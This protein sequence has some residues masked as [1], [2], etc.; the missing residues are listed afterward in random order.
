VQLVGTFWEIS[1]F[2]VRIIISGADSSGIAWLRLSAAHGVLS[3][4]DPATTSL[5]SITVGGT[6]YS[7]AQTY[8]PA[9][10]PRT[11]RVISVN[12]TPNPGSA[13]V[14]LEGGARDYSGNTQYTFVMHVGTNQ[15]LCERF[16]LAP[17]SDPAPEALLSDSG[18]REPSV[19]PDTR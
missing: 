12:V 5:S 7:V 19:D 10:D 8:Y 17:D 9:D 15:G 16:A 6:E 3:A 14:D 11:P 2:P 18:H 4:P 1:S 13:V